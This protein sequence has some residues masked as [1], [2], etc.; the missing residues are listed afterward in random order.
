M[1]LFRFLFSEYIVIAVIVGAASVYGWIMQVPDVDRTPI[2]EDGLAEI[3]EMQMLIK[4][5]PAAFSRQEKEKWS[6]SPTE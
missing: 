6:V 3:A 4:Q 5:N 2:T 1:R